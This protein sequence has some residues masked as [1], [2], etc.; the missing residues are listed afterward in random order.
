MSRLGTLSLMRQTGD[1]VRM[2]RSRHSA[3]GLVPSLR[4]WDRAFL[5]DRLGVG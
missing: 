2:R 4:R 1:A 3:G 5:N